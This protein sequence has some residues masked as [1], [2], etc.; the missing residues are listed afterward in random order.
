MSLRHKLLTATVFMGTA[1]SPAF[2]EEP[3]A[4]TVIATVN[5]TDITLGHMIATKQSLPA[6]YQQI[7]DEVLFDGI[8]D[9]LVQQTVLSQSLGNEISERAALTVENESRAILAGFAI[10]AAA[11]AAVTEET[12]TAAYDQ[13]YANA[14]PAT[15]YNASHILVETEEEAQALVVE[16][17][18][19]SDFAELAQEHSTGP[20]GPNGGALGWFAEGMM[21]PPFEAAVVALE[22]GEVSDPVETQFGWH[23]IL[24]NETRL[25]DTPSLDDVRDELAAGI[26]QAAVEGI[27]AA[28]TENADITRADTEEMEPSVLSTITLQD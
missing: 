10:D 15:E 3:S 22:V 13:Q 2:A 8:L 5:G 24:L 28:L 1:L 6:Q 9:Q 11:Q 26:Q 23:V 12:L 16:L 18:G 19:G 21:V 20:S 7:P 27:I 14:E 4:Q 17:G 25:K